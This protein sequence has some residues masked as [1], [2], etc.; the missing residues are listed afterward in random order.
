MADQ[1]LLDP[2]HKGRLEALGGH[3]VPPAERGRID[4][5]DGQLI[6]PDP[7]GDRLR[8]PAG[9]PV[10]SPGALI[11]AAGLHRRLG[12]TKPVGSRHLDTRWIRG[13]L[14]TE[15]GG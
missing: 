8:G 5:G 13:E 15:E 6:E 9:L 12:L 3:L 1:R 14:D 2:R 7:L 10:F 11:D 4:V